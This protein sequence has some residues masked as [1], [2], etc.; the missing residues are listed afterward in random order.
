MKQGRKGTGQGSGGAETTGIV[1]A[2]AAC[3]HSLASD[4]GLGDSLP[5]P[6]LQSKRRRVRHR[7][8]PNLVTPSHGGRAAAIGGRLYSHHVCLRFSAPHECRCTARPVCDGA[9]DRLSSA[10]GQRVP[11]PVRPR[12]RNLPRGDPK[13]QAASSCD[14]VM[15][16]RSKRRCTV[17]SLS[18]RAASIPDVCKSG[19]LSGASPSP[20]V[21]YP[22][23]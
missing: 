22:Q 4:T 7:C 21:L 9:R 11:V 3:A 13:I 20:A 14:D 17:T 23:E 6:A 12:H 2:H 19:C 5:L 1:R 10:A 15:G 16:P 8:Q 18:P